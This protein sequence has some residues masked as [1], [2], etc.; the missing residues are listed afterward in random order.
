MIV[1]GEQEGGRKKQEA[2]KKG[3]AHAA[4][5]GE[6][7]AVSATIGP[8]KGH[9]LAMTTY[10]SETLIGSQI[11]PSR[12]TNLRSAISASSSLCVTITKV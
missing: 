2:N 8:A 5:V 3:E 1:L 12:I 6:G 11:T 9:P 4:K 7:I 10:L